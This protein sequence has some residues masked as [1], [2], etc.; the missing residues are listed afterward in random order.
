M[1]ETRPVPMAKHPKWKPT[2]CTARGMTCGHADQVEDRGTSDDGGADSTPAT[3]EQSGTSEHNDK[4]DLEA[5]A[6]VWPRPGRGFF[7]DDEGNAVQIEDNTAFV[8]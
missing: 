3:S 8:T 1:A 5:V 2:S 4:R 7:T 6:E